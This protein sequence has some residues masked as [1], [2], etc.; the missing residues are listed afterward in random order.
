MSPVMEMPIQPLMRKVFTNDR[1]KGLCRWRSCDPS[2][3]RREEKE[4]YLITANEVELPVSVSSSVFVRVTAC[5]GGG[6]S[7]RHQHH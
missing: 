4:I 2:V 3:R 7:Q 1:E 5:L 6:L